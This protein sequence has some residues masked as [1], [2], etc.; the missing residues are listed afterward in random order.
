LGCGEGRLSRELAQRGYAVVGVDAAP[1]LV[2]AARQRSPELDF[3]VADAASLPFPD[4]AF[5]CVVAFM[6]LQDIDDYAGALCE[7]ARVLEPGGRCC[8]AVVHPLNSAGEFMSEAGDSPF[9]I[10]G[11]YLA[12]SFYADR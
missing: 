11:S 9:V 1:E 8:V 2:D 5:D 12:T 7:T 4:D 6:S 3:H 10:K